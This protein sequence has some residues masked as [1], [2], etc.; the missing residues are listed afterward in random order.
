MAQP[1]ISKTKGVTNS[2]AQSEKRDSSDGTATRRRVLQTSG[3]LL[4]VGVGAG[5]AG[6]L[7]AIDGGN[8]TEGFSD[9]IYST[10]S[11]TSTITFVFAQDEGIFEQQNIDLSVEI[12]HFTKAGRAVSAGLTPINFTDIPSISAALEEGNELYLVDRWLS[13]HDAMIAPA[14]SDIEEVPDLEGKVLG[15][16]QWGSA[17]T[18]AF[19]AVC[20][21]QFD[22]DLRNDTAET[23]SASPQAIWTL[24]EDGEIDAMAQWA[25]QTIRA[26]ARDD[27]REFYN[28]YGAWENQTG[29]P[30][31][32]GAVVADK[33]WV[34]ENPNQALRWLQAYDESLE[35]HQ[36]RAS[37]AYARYGRLIGLNEE[38][39]TLSAAQQL[40]DD[41]RIYAESWSDGYISSVRDYMELLV[42][43]DDELNLVPD[44]ER[45]LMREDL[46]AMAE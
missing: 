41:G 21:E 15:V 22:F 5:T 1:T 45:F 16:P 7:G 18:T 4:A 33:Q 9:T 34:D 38:E 3:S 46:E 17:T 44:R 32:D 6:C 11:S 42:G 8:Q 19:A 37:D 26:M 28:L 12:A 25:S 40:A 10:D 14:D 2:G 27:L 23:V 30:P 13:Q 20:Q 36:D 29:H 39:G 43:N 31:T 24:L 35:L